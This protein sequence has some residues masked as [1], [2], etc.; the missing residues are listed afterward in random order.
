M[1]MNATEKFQKTVIDAVTEASRNGV[2]P[3]IVYTVL[4]GLQTDVLTA[5]K[6]SNRLARKAA[7]AQTAKTILK[8]ANSN[9]A[10]V[11]PLSQPDATD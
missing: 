5:I 8:P 3:A 7:V 10:N 9:P 4:G 1:I 2:H 6:E 11:I